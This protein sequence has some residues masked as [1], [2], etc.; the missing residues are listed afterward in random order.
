[1][2]Q[3]KK[4]YTESCLNDEEEEEAPCF[5]FSPPVTIHTH[6][7][8]V[9][10]QASIFGTR[11]TL[12]PPPPGGG[13]CLCAE[14]CVVIFGRTATPCDVRATCYV[15]KQNKKKYFGK[16]VSVFAVISRFR[17]FAGFG[18]FAHSTPRWWCYV[19]CHRRDRSCNLPVTGRSPNA[20]LANTRER[21]LLV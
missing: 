8:A 7:N 17:T 21:H 5:F 6:I 19:C 11:N 3:R 12:P 1:M 20:E 16:F 15:N 18:G 14:V 13:T 10:R 2:Q 4:Q 9:S